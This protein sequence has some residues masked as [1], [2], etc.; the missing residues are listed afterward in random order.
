LFSQ[1]AACNADAFWA[2]VNQVPKLPQT[3][4]LLR[5]T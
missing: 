5:F 1:F 3:Q 2:A 4:H